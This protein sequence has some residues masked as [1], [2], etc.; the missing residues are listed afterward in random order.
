MTFG[1]ARLHFPSP[2][3]RG[4]GARWQGKKR[5]GRRTLARSTRRASANPQQFPWRHYY[6]KVVVTSACKPIKDDAENALEFIAFIRLPARIEAKAKRQTVAQDSDNERE[7]YKE[8]REHAWN[9]FVL[10]SGKRMQSLNFFLI[11][12]A[13]LVASYGALLKLDPAIA[14]FV[15]VMGALM[16]FFFQRLEMRTR[17][18]I[19]A[20]E[21]VLKIVQSGSLT[22]RGN[23]QH[24]YV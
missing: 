10:H 18:M 11:A 6:A 15:A 4:E 22:R 2:R 20:S 9:W 23:R 5:K 12:T 19:H 1:S 14:C 17:Q 13:F 3:P 16:A 21:D 7:L 24:S 8:V